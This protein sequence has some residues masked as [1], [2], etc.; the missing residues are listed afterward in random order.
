MHLSGVN[1]ATLWLDL[2]HGTFDCAV[3][4]SCASWHWAIL[5]EMDVWEEHGHAVA[6][7]KMYLPGSFDVA[8]QDPSLQSNSWYKV[9]E[10]ITWIYGLC[11]ALLYGILPELVWWN[12]CK[13][14]AGL[15]IM[16]QYSITP[17]QLQYACQ[18]ITQ[19]AAEFEMDHIPFIHPCV[20]L[21]CHLASEAVHWTMERTIGNLGQEIHQPLDPFQTLHNRASGN[22]NLHASANLGKGYILLVKHDWYLT[23]VQGEEARVIA[24]YL[25]LPHAPKICRWACLCLPNGQIAQSQFQELQKAPEDIC[26][27]RNVKVS[28]NGG[29]WIMEVR[30]FARLVVT[31]ADNLPVPDEDLDT[32][33]CCCFTDVALITLYSQPDTDLLEKSYGVLPSCTKLGE[34]SL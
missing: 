7:C 10:Y 13:F 29:D 9:T 2:W 15:R 28:L 19:W 20:H 30:Y 27:A 8:P 5:K 1:M 11:P 17:R 26:M 12:F 16:S 4:D 23:T 24:E 25:S 18:L 31:A 33:D 34:A 6:T 3:T 14:V 22:T 21:T 32:P